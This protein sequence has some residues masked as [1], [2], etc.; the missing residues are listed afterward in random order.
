M[1]VITIPVVEEPFSF[2]K[3]NYFNPKSLFDAD[4]CLDLHGF[5][6]RDEFDAKLKEINFAIRNVP[7]LSKRI[8]TYS[9]WSYG[10]TT[11]LMSAIIIGTYSTRSYSGSIGSFVFE[12]FMSIGYIVIKIIVSEVR[13]RRAKQFTVV[14]NQLFEQ[15]NAQDNPTANWKLAW[16]S[17][18]THYDIKMKATSEGDINGKATPKYASQAEI[19]LEISDALSSLMSKTVHFKLPPQITR[20]M[21]IDTL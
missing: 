11:V 20:E 15:Y 3:F 4:W 17:V 2:S 21:T 9:D 12:I 10:L 13:E 7:L 8:K 19:V 16:R 18:I 5:L 1:K 6:T 14:L